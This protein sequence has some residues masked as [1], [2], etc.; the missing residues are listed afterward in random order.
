MNK[1]FVFVM[2][3]LAQKSFG[4]IPV[5]VLVGHKQTQFVSYWQKDLDNAK[6]FNFFSYTSFAIDH[7]ND[8]YN[9]FSIDNQ[10]SYS[11]KNWIGISVGGGYAGMNFVPSVGLN[12]SYSNAKG[13]FFIES[14][15]TLQFDKLKSFSLFGIAGYSPKFNEKWGLFSQLIFSAN[16]QIDKTPMNPTRDVLGLFAAHQQSTQLIRVGL[17]Y[18]EKY[19]FGFGTDFMQSPQGGGNFENLGVFFRANL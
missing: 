12:L 13:D 1:I 8:A 16:L 3:L 9:N 6:K 10:L 19:Q 5:E 14:Y 4:Q 11:I 2:M 15:P 7:K 18:K 17:D